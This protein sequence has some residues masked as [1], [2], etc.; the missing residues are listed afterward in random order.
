MLLKRIA[1]VLLLGGVLAG[2]SGGSSPDPTPPPATDEVRI[3]E[4]VQR[5]GDVAD[6]LEQRQAD[7][8]SL[9][10]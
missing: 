1:V 6:G 10:P 2:C 7:L 8:E 4:M 3:G 9:L 5:A